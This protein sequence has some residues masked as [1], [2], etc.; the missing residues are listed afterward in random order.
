MNIKLLPISC[1]LLV[2]CVNFYAIVSD[3]FLLENLTYILYFLIF[4]F[5]LLKKRHGFNGLMLLFQVCN[6]LAYVARLFSGKWFV[7]LSLV[8]FSIA[9][10]AIIIESSKHIKIKN[11]NYYMFG[12]LLIIL[13]INA[14]FMWQH[15]FEIKVY[16]R[17]PLEYYFYSL[18]Y[19]NLMILGITAFVYYL[20]SYSTKSMYFISLALC[21]IFSDVLKDMSLFYFK[22]ISVEIAQ[23]VIRLGSAFFVML[24]FITK[25]K[26]LRLLN[27]V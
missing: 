10:T 16:L 4:F 6:I 21:I 27:V 26:K 13:G 20:N 15:L 18:F 1:I 14:Y 17:T 7:E 3:L 25:E 8:F 9:Y 19:L 2:V 24:F 23:S 22:D 5:F 11:A 12:Y